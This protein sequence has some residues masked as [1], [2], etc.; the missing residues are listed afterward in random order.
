MFELTNEKRKCVGLLPVKSTWTL[1]EVKA[2]PYDDFQTY[3]YVDGTVIRKCILSGNDRFL[4]YELCE[5]LTE[6]LKYLLPKTAK[7]KPAL[8]SSST[9]I[10][11]IEANNRNIPQIPSDF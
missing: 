11:N 6:D 7:G 5:Q 1:A 2:S 4:E 8:L 9:L 3:V 10:L